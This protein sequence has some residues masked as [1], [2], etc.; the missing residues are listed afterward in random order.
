M[1]LLQKWNGECF[2]KISLKSLGLRVQLNHA[3]SSCPK[4]DPAHES[5]QILHSNGIHHV[6][7]DFCGCSRQLSKG[8]QLLRRGFYPASQ[9]SPR[10]C[11]TFRLM[12]LLHMLAL[13]SK[14]STYDFYRALE[15][16]TNNTGIDVPRSRYR[17][18]TRMVRQW[19]HLKKLKRGGRGHD[20]G[21]PEGTKNGELAIMCPSC[22]HEG[23]NLPEGWQ[24]APPEWK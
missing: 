18:L 22:P 16:L 10:T 23:I 12:E 19:R 9:K 7:L 13:T 8:V 6:S 4:P 21:G 15:K 11:A 5:F 24:Q 17:A 2:V 3:R 20:S 14:G 1:Y